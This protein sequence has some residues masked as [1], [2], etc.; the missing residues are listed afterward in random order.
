[1]LYGRHSGW[2]T[3][4]SPRQPRFNSRSRQR[5]SL[6]SGHHTGKVGFPPGVPVLP[7]NSKPTHNLKSFSH[8]KKAE[9]CSFHLKIIPNF[10]EYSKLIR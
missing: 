9:N 6:V 7:H 1:M 2:Y 5:L 3:G 4:F 10:C 8:N